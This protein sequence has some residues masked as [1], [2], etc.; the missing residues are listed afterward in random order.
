[1]SNG[2]GSHID[3]G[4]FIKKING[5]E[6]MFNW[7]DISNMLDDEKNITKHFTVFQ[8]IMNTILMIIKIFVELV[9]VT[10]IPVFIT[11]FI[12]YIIFTQLILPPADWLWEKIRKLV[13]VLMPIG[14]PKLES[15]SIPYLGSITLFPGFMPFKFVFNNIFGDIWGCTGSGTGQFHSKYGSCIDRFGGKGEECYGEYA[16]DYTLWASGKGITDKQLCQSQYECPN[17]PENQVLADINSIVEYFAP[18][19]TKGV[20]KGSAPYKYLEC[21]KI[22]GNCNDMDDASNSTLLADGTPL[23]YDGIRNA[24]MDDNNFVYKGTD[25]KSDNFKPLNMYQ[26]TKRF[27]ADDRTW[28]FS[29]DNKKHN[30]KNLDRGGLLGLLYGDMLDEFTYSGEA[31]M[32]KLKLLIYGFILI[33]IIIQIYHVIMRIRYGKL[34]QDASSSNPND[35]F[36]IVSEYTNLKNEQ[37]VEFQKRYV[38][39]KQAQPYVKKNNSFIDMIKSLHHKNVSKQHKQNITAPNLQ[40]GK[41]VTSKNDGVGI[42]SMDDLSLSSKLMISSIMIFTLISVSVSLILKNRVNNKKKKEY[43]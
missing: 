24:S 16:T 36:K 26:A 11:M 28:N 30:C 37:I 8:E 31:F 18:V 43:E 6:N 17:A 10:L 22:Q 4:A 34:I 35:V 15:P 13:C 20:N 29:E 39:D 2:F 32:N 38:S 5:G 42:D 7:Y 33:L 14:V 27:F 19:I 25:S 1:M 23:G 40:P 21:C 3:M 41:Q 9:G 12:L